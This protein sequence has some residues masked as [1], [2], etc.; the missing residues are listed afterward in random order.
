LSDGSDVCCFES[1]R[2]EEILGN[3]RSPAITRVHEGKYCFAI[4]S[5]LKVVAINVGLVRVAV[6]KASGVDGR[7]DQ[8]AVIR[9][10]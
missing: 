5:H 1:Q 7:P 4:N 3:C 2:E 9:P 10:S 6:G 8:L